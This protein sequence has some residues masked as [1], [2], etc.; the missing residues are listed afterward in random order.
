MRERRSMRQQ[1]AA[2]KRDITVSRDAPLPNA[3]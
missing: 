2:L 1:P 3:V